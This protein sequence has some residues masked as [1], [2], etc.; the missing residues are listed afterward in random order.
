MRLTFR[1]KLFLL[2]GTAAASFAVLVTADSLL[3]SRMGGQLAEIQSRYIPFIELGP[4]LQADFARIRR[5]FQ[6]GVA[7]QDLEAI[8]RTSAIRDAF[9]STL[10]ESGGLVDPDDATRLRADFDAYYTAAADLSR[11]LV[12]GE[13]GVALV[14]AMSAMQQKQVRVDELLKSATTLDRN[15][16]GEAFSEIGRLQATTARFIL[17]IGVFCLAILILLS[18]GLGRGL[19]RSLAG[20]SQ[21]FARFG[22]GDF[23][24]PIPVLGQDEL[25]DVAVQANQMAER[26]RSLMRELESFSYSVAHDLR[27]PLRSML[28]FGTVL[29]EDHQASLAPEAQDAVARVMGSARK[30]G[31][32]IDSLLSLSR[33]ART[34]MK[35]EAVDLSGIAR[36]VLA[37][38]RVAHPSR[39][40]EVTVQEGVAVQGD[41]QLLQIVL[42]NLL[43]N[44]WKFTSKLSGARIE[45]GT[46]VYKGR[47]VYLV[48][49][50]GVGFDMQHTSKL[51]GTFQRL[52]SAEEFEGTGIGLATVQTIVRRH[53]GEIWADAS[54]GAGAAFRFTMWD[55]SKTASHG[56]KTDA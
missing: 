47:R 14:S 44:A 40:V 21:G 37:D 1:A 7:A 27:A 16:L 32:L 41:F 46:E 12:A 24:V 35:R 28:G 34:E 38:L 17:G 52:H 43:G 36:T 42:V 45:F 19:L 39:Q 3:S 13:A 5:G 29:V 26:I 15:R 50:N 22:Q 56:R 2:V 23:S 20:L 53:G 49:D 31:L 11:R 8:D 9:L 54:P 6:D 51:F 10:R 4:Q 55:K 33:L 30:M 18:L 25:G 48:R